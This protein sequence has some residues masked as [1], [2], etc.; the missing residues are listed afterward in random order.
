MNKQRNQAAVP[1]V[2]LS[3]LLMECISQGQEVILTVTGDSMCPFLRHK[4]DQVVLAAADPTA[5]QPG[6]VPLYRRPGGQHVLHRIVE[7]DDG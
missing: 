4:R 3:P 5:L 1:M 7:R 6:D 2:E